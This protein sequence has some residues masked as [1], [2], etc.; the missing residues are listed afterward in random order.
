LSLANLHYLSCE[1]ND[2][3]SAG[4]TH[5]RFAGNVQKKHIELSRLL[6]SQRLPDRQIEVKA[7]KYF[8]K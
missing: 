2:I 7:R 4:V 1:Q 3:Y 8:Q 6:L 5:S